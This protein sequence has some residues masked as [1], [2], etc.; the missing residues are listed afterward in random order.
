ML[1]TVPRSSKQTRQLNGDLGATSGR[2]GT[3]FRS[4]AAAARSLFSG[5]DTLER[6]TAPGASHN[7]GER[8]KPSTCSMNV[9][10][11]IINYTMDWVDDDMA[12]GPAMMWLYGPGGAGKSS[13]CQTIAQ[14][15]HGRG[16]LAAS[17]FFS[18]GVPGRNNEKHLMA[19]LAYQIS[20]SIPETRALIAHAV[21]SD[22]HIFS[23]SLEVQLQALIVN[24]LV[25]AWEAAERN[26]NRKWPS[27]IL[28]DGLDQCHGANIQR[29]I[30]R[31]LSTALIQRKLPLHV[32]VS[33]KP[34]PAI[35]DS[36]NSYDLRDII[37]TLVLDDNYLNDAEIKRY[38]WVKFDHIKQT[39]PL[40]TYI[41]SSWPPSPT[42]NSLIKRS[43]G[44]YVYASTVV[45][46]VDS[47]QHRPVER[48]EA[49]LRISNRLGDLPF[50]EVDCLYRHIF[51]AVHNL[52]TVLRVL[53][54][55]FFAQKLFSK[56]SVL[57]G[58]EIV[59]PVSDPRFLEELLSLNRGDVFFLLSD[60]HAILSVPDPRRSS[61]PGTNP[62]VGESGIK[63]L[64]G[65]LQ[66]FL[67]D[68]YRAGKY[69]INSVKQHAELARS[70]AKNLLSGAW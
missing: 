26:P 11:A 70:C 57:V 2:R 58:A 9:R 49:V 3:L 35:R 41:P 30:V 48:L 39:H 22:P 24:P 31:I 50:A 66:E 37:C 56:R 61:A 29:Y 60:L 16:L 5:M 18:K 45:R 21:E 28:I 68:R 47:S 32:L 10:N 19:T 62:R 51:A 1:H 69:F 23:S 15:C 34:E 38:L 7:S 52:K 64:H 25:H 43:T 8:F 63:V 46:Y 44:Q 54:A 14:I 65:S 33:S 40:R 42:I 53:G 55:I 13:I 17:F 36:F 27:L 12:K 59:I 20:L 67:T 4:H 6:R